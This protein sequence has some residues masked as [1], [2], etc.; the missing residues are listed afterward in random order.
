MHPEMLMYFTIDSGD[1]QNSSNSSNSS[2]NKGS[3]DSF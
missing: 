2:E 1:R 3:C